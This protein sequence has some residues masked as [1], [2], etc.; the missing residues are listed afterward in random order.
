MYPLTSYS[1]SRPTFLPPNYS[2]KESATPCKAVL[3]CCSSPLRSSASWLSGPQWVSLWVYIGNTVICL[4]IYLSGNFRKMTLS[5]YDVRGST[6]LYSCI[7]SQPLK[8]VMAWFKYECGLCDR[9]NV[10]QW[11]CEVCHML[12]MESFGVCGVPFHM[13]C[14]CYKFSTTCLL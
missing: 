5:N 3:Q 10:C 1:V 2:V 6:L 7:T 11:R 12:W 4:V 13:I 14:G 9:V 8:G